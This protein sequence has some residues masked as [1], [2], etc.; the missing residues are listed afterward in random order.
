VTWVQVQPSSNGQQL[1]SDITHIDLHGEVATTANI[2]VSTVS[3]EMWISGNGGQTW[4][5]K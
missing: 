5:K 1:S 3:K 4:E 2:T